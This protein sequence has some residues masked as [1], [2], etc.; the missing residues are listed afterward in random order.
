MDHDVLNQLSSCVHLDRLLA[1]V[2]PS[3]S[4]V[5]QKLCWTLPAKFSATFVF[6]LTMIIGSIDFCHFIP[7]S[8][9]LALAWGHKVSTCI[10]SW[11]FLAQFSTEWDEILIGW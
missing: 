4:L 9:T 1:T 8:V 2:H 6:M 10:S 5:R 11:F 3:G 7:L